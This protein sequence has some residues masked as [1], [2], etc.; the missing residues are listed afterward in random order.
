MNSSVRSPTGSVSLKSVDI[1]KLFCCFKFHA[2]LHIFVKRRKQIQINKKYRTN[3]FSHQP[4]AGLT[5][6]FDKRR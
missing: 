5:H 6:L 2:E 3:F 4:A 1:L